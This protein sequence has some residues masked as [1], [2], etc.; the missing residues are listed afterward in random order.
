MN[1]Q[2]TTQHNYTAEELTNLLNQDRER[3]GITVP[4]GHKY[5]LQELT[6]KLAE[7]QAKHGTGPSEEK[8]EQ[9]MKFNAALK[10]GASLQEESQDPLKPPFN[11]NERF[12]NN[13]YVQSK[14]VI[15]KMS[16][17]ELGLGVFATED[18]K[19]GE[20][21][22]RCPMIQMS[23]RSRYLNDPIISKY[24]YSDSGCN[25]EHCQLH[26]HHMYMVLGYGMIYNHQNEPNTEWRFNYKNLIAD[27]IAIKP[28]NAN[29][30]IFVYYGNN[31]FN[32]REYFDVPKLKE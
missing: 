18:I 27:V 26:G 15:V 24:L 4:K 6:D 10:G 22:E 3:Q 5:S 31:Y 16:N 1:Q 23:W 32:N 19:I 7:E 29:E 21:I 12:E 11:Q 2:P 20:L 30:E 25:C 14:K 8:A 17:P 28:I 13:E 9:L